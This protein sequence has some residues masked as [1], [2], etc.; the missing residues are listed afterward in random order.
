MKNIIFLLLISTIFYGC[1]K[2]SMQSGGM[3]AGSNIPY[4]KQNHS[5]YKD[6]GA[7]FSPKPKK[8]DNQLRINWT[9]EAQS[10]NDANKLREHIEFMVDR[11]KRGYTPRGW[12]KLFLMEAYMKQNHYYTTN[13]EQNGKIVVVSKVAKNRCAYS[14]ISAHADAVGNDFFARGVINKDYSSIAENILNSTQ[15][16]SLKSDIEDFISKHKMMK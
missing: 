13:V 2:E 15:C 12:D 8:L 16:S 9:I 3:G 7:N 10:Q 6:Y 1:K 11:L 14:V 4:L 5:N